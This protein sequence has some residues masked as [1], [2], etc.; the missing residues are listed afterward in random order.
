MAVSEKQ[1]KPKLPCMNP[2]RNIGYIMKEV[3]QTCGFCLAEALVPREDGKCLI[4]SGASWHGYSLDLNFPPNVG[5]PGRCWRTRQLQMHSDVTKLPPTV[6]LRAELAEKA[7]LRGCVAIPIYESTTNQVFVVL[8]LASF[9]LEDQNL[10]ARSWTITRKM[11]LEMELLKNCETS[12]MSIPLPLTK[13]LHMHRRCIHVWFFESGQT[14]GPSYLDLFLPSIDKSSIQVFIET[15]TPL[16]YL[17]VT[18]PQQHQSEFK[19]LTRPL[20]YEELAKHF[21]KSISEAADSLSM[22]PSAIKSVCRSHG[23]NSR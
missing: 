22:C 6:F 10:I 11:E 7:G 20:W 23:S 4:Q 14:F 8:F 5:V 18:V 13:E 15:V 21:H 3:S 17:E 19:N 12:G 16:T 9:A 2:Q 1:R